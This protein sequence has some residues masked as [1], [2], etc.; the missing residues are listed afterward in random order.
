MKAGH[1]FSCKKQSCFLEPSHDVAIIFH[2]KN[3]AVSEHAMLG[4]FAIKEFPNYVN[5]LDNL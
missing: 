2:T 1:H 4:V 3:R 5:V